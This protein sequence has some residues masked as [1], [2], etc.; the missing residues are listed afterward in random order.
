MA[1]EKKEEKVKQCN[2][3]KVK[4][5]DLIEQQA[6]LQEQINLLDQRKQQLLQKLNQLR[7]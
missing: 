1:E 7:K 2:F 3:I 4:L 5:Y 6:M